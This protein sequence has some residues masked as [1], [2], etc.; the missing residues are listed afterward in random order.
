MNLTLLLSLVVALVGLIL[1]YV[2]KGRASAIG[3]A[4][5][6]AGLAALL[7]QVSGY[8]VLSAGRH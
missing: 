2:G 5:F 4:L 7:V 1:F 3:L 8:L 6:T